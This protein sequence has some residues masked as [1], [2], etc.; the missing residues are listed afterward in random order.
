MYSNRG[1]TDYAVAHRFALRS[2]D[3]IRPGSHAY[4]SCR[5]IVADPI[6][7]IHCR[8]TAGPLCRRDC[9]A[10]SR[11]SFPA[12]YMALT[13]RAIEASVS[14]HAP[15]VGSQPFDILRIIWSG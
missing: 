10:I 5:L 4:R 13:V 7:A 11:V 2:S 3:S 6:L 12:A 1:P 15:L 9:A 14:K 8:L